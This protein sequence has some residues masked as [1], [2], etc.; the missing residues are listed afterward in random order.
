LA[1]KQIAGQLALHNFPLPAGRTLFRSSELK[2]LTGFAGDF[3]LTS[4]AQK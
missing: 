4:S 1:Y 3:L 2:K